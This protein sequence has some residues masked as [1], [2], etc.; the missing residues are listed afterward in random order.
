MG[1][2]GSVNGTSTD[3]YLATSLAFS[4]ARFA[5]QAPVPSSTTLFS[6]GVGFPASKVLSQFSQ[7]FTK[8]R[9]MSDMRVNYEPGLN[10][11]NP[12]SLA[13]NWV[14]DPANPAY[15]LALSSARA[16]TMADV[17]DAPHT[18]MFGGWSPAAIDLPTDRVWRYT[19]TTPVFSG[20]SGSA[21]AGYEPPTIRETASGLLSL[22]GVRIDGS[23][24]YQTGLLFIEGMFEFSD[25]LPG[26]VGYLLTRPMLTN[27]V[28]FDGT[29]FGEYGDEDSK[30]TTDIAPDDGVVVS[31]SLT[32]V[33]TAPGDSR[34]RVELLAAKMLASRVAAIS[35]SSSSSIGT[36]RDGFVK[37]R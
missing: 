6:V 36:E 16:M 13:L 1:V 15:G 26:S 14:Q 35:S 28:R 30:E 12:L 9:H 18:T 8:W 33:S 24:S 5:F 22:G 19:W 21:T 34:T 27:M 3:T 23:A 29:T 11:N 31:T 37:H 20:S 25:P 7:V 10:T 17:D 32:S 2:F 4:P